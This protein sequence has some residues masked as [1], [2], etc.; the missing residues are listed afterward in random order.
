[1]ALVR[2]L[3][4]GP[5]ALHRV[6]AFGLLPV[7]LALVPLAHA[8]PP[9]QTWLGGFYDDADFDDVVLAAVSASGIV[10]DVVLLSTEAADTVAGTV[11]PPPHVLA[12]A[13]DFSS[14]TSRA[15]PSTAHIA[16]K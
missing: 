7:L 1:M 4:S 13:D 8:N 12:V 6:L 14:F 10:T 15:P 11:W 2:S 9:D 16:T 5:R 3:A